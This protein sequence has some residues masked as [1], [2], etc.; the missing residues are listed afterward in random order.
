MDKVVNMGPPPQKG[1]RFSS[2][3]KKEVLKEELDLDQDLKPVGL[4]DVTWLDSVSHR[5][6]SYPFVRGS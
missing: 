3:A 5:G 1:M 6:P 4:S 2:Q